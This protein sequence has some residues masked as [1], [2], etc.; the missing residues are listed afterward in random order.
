[1]SASI[2]IEEIQSKHRNNFGVY[3]LLFC[4][5][6][7]LQCDTL[8]FHASLFTIRY[9]NLISIILLVYFFS[10]NKV[11][12]F[13]KSFFVLFSLIILS[14]FVSFSISSFKY[15]SGIFVGYYI[16]SVINYFYISYLMMLYYHP[17]R[18]LKI[19]L[20][21]F[22]T[23]GIFAI[24]QFLWG[25]IL[26][27]PPPGAIVFTGHPRIYRVSAFAYEP[28]YYILYM[29]LF[30]NLINIL[31]MNRYKGAL[32]KNGVSKKLLLLSNLC[33]LIAL[34]TSAML[35]YI[36]FFLFS[37]LLILF[38]KK[39]RGLFIS[40]LR[41]FTFFSCLFVVIIASSFLIR[42]Q[43]EDFF[44][45]F[46]NKNF[47]TH[48]SYV[49]RLCY[50]WESLDTMKKN[51]LF[52]VGQGAVPYERLLSKENL[53]TIAFLNNQELYRKIKLYEPAN[54]I[55]EILSGQ[56]IVGLL[57]FLILFSMILILGFQTIL[58][59]KVPY[60]KKQVIF[61]FIFSYI[62]VLIVLQLSQG[63]FRNYLWVHVGLMVGYCLHLEKKYHSRS[64]IAWF[65]HS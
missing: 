23:I 42:S 11:L 52:G 32:F 41:L 16:F 30:V 2:Y 19:Y 55:A 59:D 61:A 57:L 21:S 22:L 6:V 1:M 18:V 10:K 9:N 26:A 3:F 7:T 14:F 15:R 56:G 36:V 40:K 65:D 5:F 12:V 37:F 50:I 39:S 63:L 48:H 43:I 60:K 44:L 35:N 25:L 46:L 31:Y 8:S 33:Y 54:V 49:E 38:R 24:F 28:S 62:I 34:S 51:I 13:N 45:R 20:V 53:E 29:T 17:E 64:K 58:N 4:Y 27:T 47:S